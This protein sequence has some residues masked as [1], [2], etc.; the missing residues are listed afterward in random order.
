MDNPETFHQPLYEGGIVVRKPHWDF[1]EYR[2]PR[3]YFGK[4]TKPGIQK[5]TKKGFYMDYMLKVAKSIPSARIIIQNLEQ[6][7]TS[8]NWSK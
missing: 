4:S 7:K 1:S 5:A 8:D 3:D 2:T 6:Y